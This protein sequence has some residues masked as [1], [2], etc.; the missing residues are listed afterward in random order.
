MAE[1]TGFVAEY[2]LELLEELKLELQAEIFAIE[3]KK[4]LQER[5]VTSVTTPMLAHN[6]GAEVALEFPDCRAYRLYRIESNAP[7][8]FRMYTTDLQRDQDANRRVGKDPEQDSG[9]MLEFITTPLLLEADL[10]PVVDGFIDVGN[11]GYCRIQN[12]SG[13]TRTIEVTLTYIR[14]E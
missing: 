13:V 9:L 3:N 14:T 5:D 12:R 1:V 10:S 4:V 7:C 6:A 8:R 11:F 2:V